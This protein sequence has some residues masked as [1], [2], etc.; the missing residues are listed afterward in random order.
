MQDSLYHIVLRTSALTLSLVL[1]F[2]SGII[3]PVTQQISKD[4]ERYLATAIGMYAAVE[5]NGLNEMTAALTERDTA[6]S[7]REAAIAE[8][9]LALGLNEGAPATADYTTFILSVIVFILLVLIV[10]NYVM[11][12]VRAAKITPSRPYGRMA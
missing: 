3:S 1:L 10:L 4:T 8:R 12:Y 6:L 11:D 5:P 9:E 7:V 2:V